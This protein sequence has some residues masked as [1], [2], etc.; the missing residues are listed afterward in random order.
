MVDTAT[1]V[2]G[3]GEDFFHLGQRDVFVRQTTG[4]LAVWQFSSSGAID[5]NIPLTS[6]GAAATIDTATLVAGAGEDFF[7]TGQ[8]DVFLRTAAGQLTVWQVSSSG[9]VQSTEALT[10]AGSIL[11]FDS[12]T[13]VVGAGEDFLRLTQRDIFLRQSNGQLVIW[14][15]S[16]SGAINGNIPLTSG[17]ANVTIDTATTAVGAG[18]DFFGTGQSDI[19]R[20]EQNG[21]LVVMQAA[22]TGVISGQLALTNSGS[23]LWLDTATTVIGA[24]EDYFGDA[25][26]TIFIRTSSGQL[27]AWQFSSSGAI[28]G[29]QPFT[30]SGNI[31]WIDSGTT[32]VGAGEDFLRQAQRDIFLRQSNG[33]LVIWQFSS[34][35]AIDGNTPLTSG[36]A[37][38]TIDAATTVVGAGEDFFGTGQSNVFERQASGQLVV[39]QVANNGAI[40]NTQALTNGG[41]IMWID[42]GTTVVGAGEDFFS[43]G[44]HDAFL[45]Q[46]NGQLAVCQFSGSGAIN[47]YQ[48]LT[49]G[50]GALT[51][52][53]ATTVIGVGQNFFAGAA[54][55]DI[56]FRLSSGYL[57]LAGFNASGS[58]I[59]SAYLY[60]GGSPISIDTAATV[61][62]TGVD[63]TTG[64]PD[65][66]LRYAATGVTA[67]YDVVSGLQPHAALIGGSGSSAN[68]GT[69]LPADNGQSSL[70]AGASSQQVSV[71][72]TIVASAQSD[73]SYFVV[74][75]GGND[76]LSSKAAQVTLV[77]NG[78]S[79][80]YVFD[81]QNTSET[82]LNGLSAN[83]AVSGTLQFSAGI[84]DRKLWFDRVDGSGV[85]SASGDDLRINVLGT[86][87]SVMI[88]N[89]FASGDTYAQLSQIVLNNGTTLS[90]LG[91][92]SLVQAMTTYERSYEV[93]HGGTAFNPASAANPMI[94]DSGV[95]AAMR[96]AWHN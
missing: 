82:I 4:Q 42:T 52:D 9:V 54:N 56:F 13:T 59:E 37:A 39:C 91:L 19:F 17:G 15:L 87:R 45:R 77:G 8:S 22:S 50:S 1:I 5:G 34:S 79:D 74:G 36:G 67:T 18:E 66:T 26:R 51:I 76:Q 62:G 68:G 3:A 73:G 6:G 69:A 49:G 63:Q 95:L 92:D 58:Q 60:A 85:V 25:Q 38:V 21:Q 12:G 96:N 30:N 61:I 28:D 35:G 57:F 83:Q 24:G 29:N 27:T 11:W 7:G 78:G 94:S 55:H 88:D 40:T 48:A 86:S 81:A 93:S 23:P 75:T 10:N 33:Q 41:G 84:T 72:P 90:D 31:L 16:S 14:Q 44:L 53:T 32:V 43:L 71:Q 64:V 89:W 47:G 20:R 70:V 2:V 65:F 80:T 46:A